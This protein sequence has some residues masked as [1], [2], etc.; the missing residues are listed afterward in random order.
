MTDQITVEISVEKMPF[1]RS[2]LYGLTVEKEAS[3]KM[4]SQSGAALISSAC[5]STHLM[6]R[7]PCGD[8]DA[9]AH[10]MGWLESIGQRERARVERRGSRDLDDVN[11]VSSTFYTFTCT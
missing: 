4:G 2:F 10:W 5:V 7:R 8:D 11:F 9:V 1:R 6:R 3:S